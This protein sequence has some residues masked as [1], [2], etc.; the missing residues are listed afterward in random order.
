MNKKS[1]LERKAAPGSE[2]DSR[3]GVVPAPLNFDKEPRPRR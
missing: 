2:R 3:L 1:F